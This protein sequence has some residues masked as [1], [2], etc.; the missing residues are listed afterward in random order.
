MATV[1]FSD[2]LKKEI[3]LNARDKMSPA[4]GRARDS[5]P[6]QSWGMRIYDK[7]FAN[8]IPKINALPKNWFKQVKTL[9]V[10]GIE[11]TISDLDLTFTLSHEV[12]WPADI[13]ETDTYRPYDGYVYGSDAVVTLKNHEVWSEFIEEAQAYKERLR[14]AEER[15]KEFEDMVAQVIAT[16]TTLAPALKAWPALWELIPEE[17][18]DRHREVR[19]RVKKD[20]TLDIDLNKLTAMATAAKLGA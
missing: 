6:D 19:E 15:S 10:K 9:R 18:K 8:E 7:M 11:N 16:Y 2:S 1:R 12:S 4:I 20:T 3:I 5:S 13:A 14:V 17:T